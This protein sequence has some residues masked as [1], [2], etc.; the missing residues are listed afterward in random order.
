MSRRSRSQFAGS[1]VLNRTQ[2]PSPL[3]RDPG[4]PPATRISIGQAMADR[5]NAARRW[6]WRRT[7]LSLLV[8]AAAAAALAVTIRQVYYSSGT[9]FSAVLEPPIRASLNFPGVGVLSQIDV[10]PGQTVR[11][12]EVLARQ[13]SAVA[14]AVVAADQATLAADQAKVGAIQQN[15]VPNTPPTAADISLAQAQVA[16]DTADLAAAQAALQDLVLVSPISGTVTGLAGVVGDLVGNQGV[17]S[18]GLPAAQIPTEPTSGFFPPAP[19]SQVANSNSQ[20]APLI[21]IEGLGAWQ[22]IA[23][24]PE[25]D[26]GRLTHRSRATVVADV[27]GSK[28]LSAVFTRVVASPVVVGGATYYDVVFTLTRTPAGLLPGVTANVVLER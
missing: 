4:E 5:P 3:A 19:S 20:S 28:K 1:R 18:A 21:T 7:L 8:L 24:V 23:Q 2:S 10:Q 25:G 13:N 9:Q 6:R 16:R 27:P 17:N 26:L 14:A 15:Q 11:R 22:V 12:G